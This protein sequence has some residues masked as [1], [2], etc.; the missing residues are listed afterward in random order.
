MSYDA[1]AITV[2]E[3]LDAVRKRPACTSDPPASG[4]CTW[5]TRSS[6]ARST[7]DGRLRHDDLG[8]LPP[9]AACGSSTTAVASPSTSSP[10]RASRPSRSCSP[11]ARGR[12]GGSGYP[13]PAAPRRRGVGGQRPV[14][15]LDIEVRRNG[16]VYRQSYLRGVPTA[17]PVEGGGRRPHRDDRDVLGRRRHLRD[18]TTTSRPCR[19]GP[20]DGFLNKG[21]TLGS[22][23]SAAAIVDFDDDT[24]PGW[25][26]TEHVRRVRYHYGAAS[27]TSCVTPTR[28]RAWRIPRSSTSRTR[29][30]TS[31]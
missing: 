5:S 31:A 17:P 28:A 9:M 30:T 11:S 15:T 13:C 24:D 23:T 14:T 4:A 21:L 16:H 18:H 27:R 6:V 12:L 29:P 3:G 26:E 10:A 8:D 22:S 7:G 1:S 20:G 19:A 2:L 25:P